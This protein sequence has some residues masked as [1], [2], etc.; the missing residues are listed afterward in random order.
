MDEGV[1]EMSKIRE[2]NVKKSAWIAWISWGV[3]QR[4][5]GEESNFS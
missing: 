2:R 5:D 4:K 3:L 1:L